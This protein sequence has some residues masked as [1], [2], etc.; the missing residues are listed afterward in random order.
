[1]EIG[2]G[3]G[4][5]I[6]I[7]LEPLAVLLSRKTGHP[8]KFVMSRSEVF[9]STGPTSGTYMKVKMGATKSGKITAAEANLGL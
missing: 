3:F 6:P 4:G 1:M 9:E 2:G 5:K 7:Y 8:V